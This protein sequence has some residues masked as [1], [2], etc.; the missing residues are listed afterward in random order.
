MKVLKYLFLIALFSVVSCTVDGIPKQVNETEV[1]SDVTLTFT[2]A[3]G[4]SV[5]YTY[6]DPRYRNKNYTSPVI[7][8]KSGQTYTVSTHFYNKSNPDEIEDVTQ[9]VVEEKD[10]HFLEFRFFKA[11]VNLT[12]T[13]E[14]KTTDS[15]GIPIGL[16]TQ[17]K[18]GTPT[19]NGAVQ[20]TLIHKP[21]T[22]SVQ[23]PE[24][25]HTGGETDA[26]VIF[27]L[28]IK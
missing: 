14:P 9:E 7:V 22:K 8:L 23:N 6:T 26:Q 21:L 27:E 10:D 18:A 15:N 4:Q 3:Q 16:F 24:G 17:W 20:V 5:S 1:I 13:D 28:H 11:S 2:N 12:R 25:N 19:Q